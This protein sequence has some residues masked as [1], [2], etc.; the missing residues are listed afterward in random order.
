MWMSFAISFKNWIINAN[1]ETPI[2]AIP[3]IPWNVFSQQTINDHNNDAVAK[4]WYLQCTGDTIVYYY[5][6]DNIM[7]S[8]SRWISCHDLFNR[9]M[10][11]HKRDVTPAHKWW[12]YISFAPTPQDDNSLFTENRWWCIDL[13]SHWIKIQSIHCTVNLEHSEIIV[14]WC[15]CTGFVLSSILPL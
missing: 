7:A 10:G 13:D 3:K 8:I 2:T 14:I 12:K 1:V 11:Q 6:I 4:L 9:S 15:P 5:V